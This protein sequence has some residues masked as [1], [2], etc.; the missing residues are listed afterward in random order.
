MPKMPKMLN[1][2]HNLTI[3]V[4][5]NFEPLFLQNDAPDGLFMDFTVSTLS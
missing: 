5:A 1:F 4:L 3:A 2:C